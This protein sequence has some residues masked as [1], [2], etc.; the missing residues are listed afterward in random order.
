[1]RTSSSGVE[2]RAGGGKTLTFKS[3]DVGG[4]GGVALLLH[5]RYPR[6]AELASFVLANCQ[7]LQ[8]PP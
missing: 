7:T 6:D 2:K 5:K 3:E 4:P 1:M 8:S